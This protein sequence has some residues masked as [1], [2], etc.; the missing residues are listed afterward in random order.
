VSALLAA[1]P[2]I[3]LL[4]ALGVVRFSAHLSA[5]LALVT[6]LGVARAARRAHCC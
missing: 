1:L 3:V 6:A 5:A 2:V 4:V